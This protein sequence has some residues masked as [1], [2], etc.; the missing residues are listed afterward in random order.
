MRERREVARGAD[1]ALARNAGIGLG[2]EQPG[3]G[4]EC[5]QPHAREALRQ[6]ADLEN[7]HEPHHR[8]GQPGAD[9]RGMR[10]HEI[11]LQGGELV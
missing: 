3:E 4:E 5:P 11:A 1:R 6:T 10:Q 2:L 7:Q 8:I 9:P